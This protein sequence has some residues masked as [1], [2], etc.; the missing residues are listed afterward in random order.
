MIRVVAQAHRH[1]QG[2]LAM[3]LDVAALP[4]GAAARPAP[5]FDLAARARADGVRFLLALF[6]DLTG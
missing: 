3:T 2:A 4:I 5:D 1:I 6:V